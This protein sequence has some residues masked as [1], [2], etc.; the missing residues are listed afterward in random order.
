MRLALGLW[1][2]FPHRCVLLGI[3]LSLVVYGLLAQQKP[4]VLHQC[5]ASFRREFSYRVHQLG[6]HNS[7]LCAVA[8]LTSRKDVVRS[9]AKF[10]AKRA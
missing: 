8:N 7:Q 6:F 9:R 10:G 3:I 2:E 4:G 5:D 1:L